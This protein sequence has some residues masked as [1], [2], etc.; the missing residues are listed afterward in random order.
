MQNAG[1][2][3]SS[4]GMKKKLM[5]CIEAI[6]GGVREVIICNGGKPAP[7]TAALQGNGTHI[8]KG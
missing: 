6:N 5:G 2:G 8:T 1:A 7:I 4:G 3:A